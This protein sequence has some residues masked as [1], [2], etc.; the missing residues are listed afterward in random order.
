MG[1][2]EDVFKKINKTYGAGSV[3]NLND[4]PLHDIDVIS[5]GSLVLNDALGVGGWSKGR[6]TEIYGPESSGKTTL[7]IHAIAECQKSGGKAAFID[8]EHAF[9]K[10]YAENLGVDTD[11]LIFSQ[12]DY[13]EQA[14]E[15]IDMLIET[16]EVDLL[17]VDSVAAMIPKR[18][19]EGEMGDAN[20]GVLAKMMSQAMR[21]LVGKVSK[22]NT[23]MIFI[24]QLREKIGVMFGSP[25]VTTGGRALKFAA[26]VRVDI[27]RTGS[28]KKGEEVIAN[29]VKV[30]ITKNKVAPPFKI[31]LLE[32]AFGVGVDLVAEVLTICIDADVVK[33][34]GSW[35]SYGDIKL[36][37]GLPAVKEL[38]RDNQELFC[39]L[40]ELAEMAFE[41]AKK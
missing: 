37:Q 34:N 41:E 10:E 3:G 9:D 13:G 1:K 17:I 16:G 19:L 40:K 2:L 39:E 36:G 12:P 15:M 11:S 21:K 31:A 38:L 5:S 20:V 27:R 25:E 29:T 22:T 33:R 14:L 35:Y 32:I 30:K 7:C 23:A 8:M 6:I 24:N 4:M 28:L 18:E 26:S